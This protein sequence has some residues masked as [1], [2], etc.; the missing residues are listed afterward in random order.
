[1]NGEARRRKEWGEKEK[2]KKKKKKKRKGRVG[3]V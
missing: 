3:T 2:K 1:M